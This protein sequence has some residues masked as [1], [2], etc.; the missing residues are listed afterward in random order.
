[1]FE[2]V[3]RPKIGSGWSKENCAYD[4]DELPPFLPALLELAFAFGGDSIDASSRAPSSAG[5]VFP[6]PLQET[7]GFESVES[8]IE[9]T[10]LHA[11]ESVSGLFHAFEDFKTVSGTL[12]EEG[13]NHGVEVSPEFVAMYFHHGNIFRQTGCLVSRRNFG[14]PASLWTELGKRL[15]AI[16]E[17]ADYICLQ[18]GSRVRTKA[19]ERR[20]PSRE[21]AVYF[22]SFW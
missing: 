4:F 5:S 15:A 7:C 2:R 12:F 9:G 13:E 3:M 11:E 17:I 20:T 21:R 19:R 14:M 1:M 22:F 10:F 8:R 16:Q 18:T 6:S